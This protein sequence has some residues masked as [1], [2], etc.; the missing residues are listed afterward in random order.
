MPIVL[1]FGRWRQED[2]ERT[3]TATQF[4][5]S[6]VCLKIYKMGCWRAGFVVKSLPGARGQVPATTHFRWLTTITPVP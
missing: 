3:A 4:R 2:Q 6:L 5:V 1:A